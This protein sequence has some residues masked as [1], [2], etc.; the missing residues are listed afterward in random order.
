MDE[1]KYKLVINWGLVILAFITCLGAGFRVFAPNED[2]SKRLDERTLLYIGASAI[3]LRFGQLKSFDAKIDG[4]RGEFFEKIAEKIDANTKEVTEVK[5]EFK[6]E[7]YVAKIAS[8]AAIDVAK[9]DLERGIEAPSQEQ[10]L[11]EEEIKPGNVTDDPWKGQFD[12]KS[13]NG[14]R[15]LTATVIPASDSSEYFYIKLRVESTKD[16][17]KLKGNVKFYIHPTFKRSQI[18]VPVINGLAEINLR[19]W[20]AF[21]VGAITE[22][23]TK[24]ELDLSELRDPNLSRF[25]SR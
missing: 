8:E 24:L 11:L 4:I 3:L 12:G 20:G 21:T 16:N 17:D 18:M 9:Y 19:A 23:K 7:F 6:K 15:K 25:V 22:D 5:K 10:S 1:S 13:L 14:N 2:I